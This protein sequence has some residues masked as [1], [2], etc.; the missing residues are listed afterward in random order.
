MLKRT[1]AKRQVPVQGFTELTKRIAA[2]ISLT[3]EKL[4]K[5]QLICEECDKG[6]IQQDLLPFVLKW[7]ETI[8]G[9]SC[10]IYFVLEQISIYYYV[11]W[12]MHKGEL[13]N[14]NT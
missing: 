6:K 1:Q 3:T 5:L 8:W 2:D 12:T 7:H 13:Y 4:E 10:L 14:E 11:W 9:F